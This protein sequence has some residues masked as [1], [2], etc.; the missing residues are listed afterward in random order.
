MTLSRFL[1]KTLILV[2]TR[3]TSVW[4]T[5]T[6]RCYS[7][8][9]LKS[10]IA[11]CPASEKKKDS[12]EWD[13][14]HKVEQ[15]VDPT[16]LDEVQ[17]IIELPKAR[18]P[19]FAKI[20]SRL[21]SRLESVIDQLTDYVSKIAR[22]YRDNSFHSLDHAS[23]VMSLSLS[24]VKVLSRGSRN[25]K[26]YCLWRL[27]IHREQRQYADDLHKF[28]H[29]ITSDHPL[30]QVALVFSTLIHDDVDY[31]GLPNAQLVKE[32]TDSIGRSLQ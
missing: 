22:M 26:Y 7:N 5:G 18:Q 2:T 19:R 16:V 9:L 30:T 23:H 11:R 27:D 24:V 14:L 31:S 21:S 8:C 17:E 10:I 13:H 3:Y 15:E 32:K 28:T 12:K 6:L 1:K 4:F 20:P 25:F 29:G